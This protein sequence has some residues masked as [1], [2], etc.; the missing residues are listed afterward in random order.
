MTNYEK[1]CKLLNMGVAKKHY[2]FVQTG[3]IV[4]DLGDTYD[5]YISPTD[6]YVDVVSNG[7]HDFLGNIDLEDM[8]VHVISNRY[9]YNL[10]IKKW[11]DA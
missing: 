2:T 3:S 8:M 5:G 9:R 7:S 10:P 11:E 6:K 1:A 4:L